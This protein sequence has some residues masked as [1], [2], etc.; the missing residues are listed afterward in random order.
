MNTV[1]IKEF[2]LIAQEKNITNVA[3]L[4]FT[5]PSVISR[6]L[7]QLEKTLGVTLVY[8]NTHDVRLT[9]PGKMFLE[10]ITPLVS[11]FESIVRDIAGDRQL[12][13]RIAVRYTNAFP[14]LYRYIE[15]FKKEYPDVNVIC[16]HHENL[17]DAITNNQTD[18]IFDLYNPETYSN[19]LSSIVMDDIP[20]LLGA[21]SKYDALLASNAVKMLK[22]FELIIPSIASTPGVQSVMDSLSKYTRLRFSKI[23]EAET[24]EDT[25]ISLT[26]GKR[27]ALMPANYRHV[28]PENISFH[29]M[30]FLPS[31]TLEATW[32]PKNKN[33]NVTRLIRIMRSRKFENTQEKG[34]L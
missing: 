4:C 27:A 10:R 14:K 3:K 26:T 7:S 9:E 30:P 5:A 2:L 28:F 12:D 34:R 11:E 20:I 22:D 33:Q 25:V 8:R 15:E 21:D 31:V 1:L 23:T 29:K 16:T 18:M 24:L 13:L 17:I 19:R 6:H 32:S